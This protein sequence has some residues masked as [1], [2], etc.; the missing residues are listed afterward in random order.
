MQPSPSESPWLLHLKPSPEQEWEGRKLHEAAAASTE[1]QVGNHP[2]NARGFFF[3]A[4]L[5]ELSKSLLS[6]H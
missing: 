3:E 6:G 2:A 4:E 1:R 5:G